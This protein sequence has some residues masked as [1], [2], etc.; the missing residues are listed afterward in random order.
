MAIDPAGE[1]LAAHAAADPDR[2]AVI[3]AGT[4]EVRTYGQIDAVATRSA[5]LLRARGLGVG[6]HLA[7]LVENQAEFFDVAWAANR[8]GLYVTPINWHLSAAEAGYIVGDCDATALVASARLASVVDEIAPADLAAVTTRLSVDGPID[9]FEPLSEALADVEVGPVPDEHDGMWMFY[10]SGTTGKP[11]GV[12]PPLGPAA[13]GAPS[14]V[15]MMLGGLFGFDA[16]T[17]YLSPAP[18]YHAAPAGWS[19]GTHRL[20]GTVVVM[21]HFDARGLLAAVEQFRVT[22]LQLVPTHMIRLLDLPEA[23]RARFDLSSL[24]MVVHAAAP[25]PVEVKRAFIEWVGPIVHEYYSGTE[26]SGFCRIGPEEWLAHPGS[27]GRSISGAIHIVGPDGEELPVGTEGEVWFETNRR[28]EY[29][30]DAEKTAGAW[31]EHGWSWLG[32]LGRVDDEGYL[33]L[34][35]RA[36]NLIIS[37]GVNISPRETEDVLIGHPAVADVAVVGTPHPEMGEQVTAYVQLAPGTTA[38]SD[39]LVVWC[40]DRLT[41]FKCP[42]EVRFVEELPRLPTGKLL[43]RLLPR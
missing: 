35:D 5:R 26:G 19:I 41:H 22:H 10:S 9:G 40:R 34:T 13:L 43:K 18:L 42:R 24:R 20:G 1:H 23:E 28:F 6:D 8:A 16:S 21:D 3:L 31:N 32:D 15:T 11:K 38:T 7:L 29:H 37:G 30:K 33:Y 36:G 12:V 4:G 2:V 39:E 17:V 27:V 14:F 25:C